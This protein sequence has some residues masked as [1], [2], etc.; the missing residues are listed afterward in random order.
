MQTQGDAFTRARRSR[1]L[2]SSLRSLS[3]RPPPLPPCLSSC[4]TPAQLRRET[5]D[6]ELHVP[7]RWRPRAWKYGPA[8]GTF[9]GVPSL[10]THSNKRRRLRNRRHL[11]KQLRVVV[12]SDV[13]IP[14]ELSDQGGANKRPHG[15]HKF[16]TSSQ[17]R[18]HDRDRAVYRRPCKRANQARIA[19][20]QRPV[21]DRC[22]KTA[23]GTAPHRTG[24]RLRLR[25]TR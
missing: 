1:P 18:H 16:R 24:L 7:R 3:N 25:S 21:R 6:R 14:A 12:P 5:R 20:R 23:R 4:C 19:A 11:C 15:C 2:R 10:H 13:A 8:R 22:Q 17:V 9:N